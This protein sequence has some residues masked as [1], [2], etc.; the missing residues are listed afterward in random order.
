MMNQMNQMNL[1]NQMI[2]YN[3]N[4]N[5]TFNNDFSID[6]IRNHTN[7]LDQITKGAQN[8]SFASQKIGKSPNINMQNQKPNFNNNLMYVNNINNRSNNLNNNN[9]KKN[10]NSNGIY[11][12]NGNGQVKIKYVKSDKNLLSAN[13]ENQEFKSLNNNSNKNW[14]GSLQGNLGNL[15]NISENNAGPNANTNLPLGITPNGLNGNFLKPNGLNI[16]NFNSNSSNKN[17]S[18]INN[19]GRNIPSK[20]NLK[21]MNNSRNNYSSMNNSILQENEEFNINYTEANEEASANYHNSNTISS[22][23]DNNSLN[24]QIKTT[25]NKNCFIKIVVKLDED[26]YDVIEIQKEDDILAQ[27]KEFCTK[28]NL[29]AELIKPIYNY[30]QQSLNTLGVVLEKKVD[31]NTIESLK[32]AKNQYEE[33]KVLESNYHSD[34]EIYMNQF[35]NCDVSTLDSNTSY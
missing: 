10:I 29:N 1:L 12:G 11:Q 28:N 35:N 19:Y 20:E 13:L 24:N 18:N 21:N 17:N 3:V 30:I 2:N 15:L 34:T 26:R 23:S 32:F 33:H 22:A 5:T 25:P 8:I 31:S 6:D 27:T 4:N 7:N 9:N 14:R 16:S